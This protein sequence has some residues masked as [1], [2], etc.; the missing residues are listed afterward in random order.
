VETV[1][2]TGKQAVE[3]QKR[4]TIYTVA[5]KLGVSSTTV[6]RA[7]NN[8]SKISQKTKDSILKMVKE[9]GYKPNSIAKSLARKPIRIAFIVSSG[10]PEFHRYFIIGAKQ[11]EAELK[12]Y[13]VHVDYFSNNEDGS[14]KDIAFFQTTIKKVAAGPYDGLLFLGREIDELRMITE[15]NIPVAAVVND[16]PKTK[17]CF[18]MHY[19]GETAGRM[20]GELLFWR[21]GPGGKVVLASGAETIYM[22]TLITHG[23]TEQC[24]ELSLDLVAI[25]YNKDDEETAYANT[26]AIL[27]THSE[28]QGIYVNSYNSRGVIRSIRDHNLGGKIVLITSDINDELCGCLANGIVSATIYQN[29]YRQGRLGLKYLYQCISENKSIEDTITINPEI[30]FRSNMHRY[31]QWR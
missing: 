11:T 19:D 27:D 21:L 23:F 1:E 25:I 22:H 4:V 14:D 15:K 6:Y 3:R 10:F 30:I 5:E 2:M 18:Y 7:L 31:Q 29:Q 17:R 8:K 26:N 16:M 20:A 13:N 12:D 28:I 9:L 24:K